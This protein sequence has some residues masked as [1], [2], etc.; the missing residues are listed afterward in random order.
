MD[1]WIYYCV[2]DFSV[3]PGLDQQAMQKMESDLIAKVDAIVTV[4]EVLQ[5]KVER[6][7][8][9]SKLLTHGVDLERWNSPSSTPYVWPGN[10]RGPV[11]LFWEL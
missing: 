5:K 4:S 10:V 9:T 6:L 2:D 8:Y 7:G 1:R 11:A 3:W